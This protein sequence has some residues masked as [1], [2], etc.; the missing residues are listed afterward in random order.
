MKIILF[1]VPRD[2][3][4]AHDVLRKYPGIDIEFVEDP[5]TAINVDN[6]LDT[7]ILS[8]FIHS[9]LDEKVLS[10]LDKL[11]LIATRSTGFDHVD[12]GFCKKKGILVCNVPNYAGNTVAE[13]IFGLILTIS[14]KLYDTL[15][16][17][18]NGNFSREGLCGFDLKGKT[19]GIIGLGAIGR[20]TAQIAKG[21]GM[22]V[23]GYD[24]I[25][26]P[27]LA[28]SIGFEYRSLTDVLKASDIISLNVPATA[29]TE[30]MI[31]EKEFLIMKDGVVLINT[32]RGSVV[33]SHALIMALNQGKV[34]AAGLDV[35][36]E[37]E[38]F[39]KTT[40]SSFSKPETQKAVR[41]NKILLEM[42]NVYMTPHNA[43]NT[44]EALERI[45]EITNNNITSFLEGK[46][47]NLI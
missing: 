33:N 4:V 18:R 32:A 3:R 27:A 23:L 36:P 37:E 35:V 8:T 42:P 47:K 15:S 28:K 12:C 31:G 43:F 1:E 26:D 25:K 44:Q 16:R 21:F 22:G 10:R 17:T 41:A 14:R 9:T 46:P 6:Y 39:F 7:E 11:K 24:I 2:K 38:L 13:Y 45:I 40:G 29:A 20:N 30:K 5:L 19:I 34:A